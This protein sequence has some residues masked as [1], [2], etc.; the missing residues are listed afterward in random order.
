MTTTDITSESADQ[1]HPF[2]A[3]K[4]KRIIMFGDLRDST[5]ILQNF[6][7]GMYNLNG[8]D[9]ESFTYEQFILEV[10]KSTY[11]YLYLGH[12]QTHT[13]IYGDGVMAIF[14]ED[15]TRLIMENI[16]RLT[17]RMRTYNEPASAGITR[18]N[19]D[20]GF[21]ITVGVISLVY[22]SLDERI[23]PVGIGVH[24]AARIEGMSK[25]YDARILISESFFKEAEPYI[26][27]DARFS[28]R[29]IDRV[30]LKNFREP[31]TIY[32]LLVDNDP[33]FNKKIA[34]IP[35]YAAAYEAYCNADW[36]TAKGLF[37]QAHH[38]SGLGAGL[39]MANRCKLLLQSPPISD[40][41]GVWSL[42]DK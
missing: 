40:W 11:E 42:Q 34:S 20:V 21:G 16:Y 33:R 18:P 22:Y 29:F 1:H 7:Q 26:R 24:E 17:D 13:E 28:Y 12:S 39:V 5:E 38:D 15:N 41:N 35:V 3:E 9:G 2:K 8:P 36:L 10:H 27:E 31:V 25:F 30:R 32:E 19:I 23:H 37:M 6:E 4:S 14:P